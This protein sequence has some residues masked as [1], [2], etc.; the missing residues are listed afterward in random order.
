MR[1][2]QLSDIHLSTTNLKDLK[3][4]YIQALCEDLTIFHK[5]DPIDVILITGDLVDK[6]GDSLGKTPYKIFKTEFIDKIVSELNLSPKQILFIPGNHDI[7]RNAIEP[8]TEFWLNGKLNTIEANSLLPRM[9]SKFINENKRI[10]KFKKF[11]QEYHQTNPEYEFSNNESKVIIESNGKKFGF[12]LVNDSWRCSAEL[13]EEN[14]FIGINQLLNAKQFFGEQ[15]TNFNIAVFHHPIDVINQSEK[16]EI[17]NILKS[18]NFDMAI[19]GHKHDHKFESILSPIGGYLTMQG[20]TT[21]SKTREGASKYQPGYSIVDL[22]LDDKTYTLHSRKFILARY[23]FDKDTDSVQDGTHTGQIP[24]KNNSV[25]LA[26]S[27]NNSDSALPD[28]Y[29]AEVNR[30]VTLLI[31]KSLYEDQ[32]IFIR[33]LIQNSVDAC[34]REI[35]KNSGR[36]P[37]IRVMINTTENFVEVE[38]QGDGMT[39][40]VVKQHFA[41]IGQSISHDFNDSNGKFNLISQFGI[42]FISTFIVAQ[43]V[44]IFTKNEADEP[45]EFQINDVFKGFS[46]EEATPNNLRSIETGTRVRVYLKKGYEA[47]KVLA[48]VR[49][50][51]R[52]IHNLEIYFDSEKLQNQDDWNI[53]QAIIEDKDENERYELKLA[54][55]TIT[56]P[57]IAS[58]S[59][60][61]INQSPLQLIP[62]KFPFYIGG[63]VNFKPKAIDFDM[64]RSNIIESLKAQAFRREISIYLRKFFRSALES[65]DVALKQIVLNYLHYYLTFYDTNQVKFI[66]DYIDFYSKKELIELCCKHTRFRFYGSEKP[67]GRILE[68]LKDRAINVIYVAPAITNNE[69]ETLVIHYLEDNGNLVFRQRSYTVHFRD[70]G[71]SVALIN[72]IQIVATYYGFV[73]QSTTSTHQE[74]LKKMKMDKS[75]FPK[76]MTIQLAKLEDKHNVKIDIAPFRL[77]KTSIRLNQDIFLNS[78][79]PA[80]I[81]M[82]EDIEKL[83]EKEILIYLAGLLGLEI[84]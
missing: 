29:K 14:H 19:F 49:K 13:K 79:Y 7:E 45:I 69:P 24:P 72:M 3:T 6:G 58:N 81:S 11:E 51:C 59:G 17:D 41:V 50:Y 12:V 36:S 8:K 80:F 40:E 60:F 23:K 70:G 5:G 2:V 16:E 65:E 28:S 25:A 30:I 38:D 55:G 39:K 53:S 73:L 62:F 68:I 1:F 18:T 31:G 67:L 35:Q 9:Q 15:K 77:S 10:K 46:Y 33:E 47:R 32:Y 78:N 64:S 76:K 71:Q 37:I 61:L 42:G 52:H 20:R 4:Y 84:N 83:E 26:A 44:I 21:F 34:Q 27:E 82:T 56:R 57:L 54:I 43:K 48:N 74:I 75:L 63:E 66:E 22:N